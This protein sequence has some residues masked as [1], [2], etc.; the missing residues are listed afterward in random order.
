LALINED[1]PER[2][3]QFRENE[4]LM[5]ELLAKSELQIIYNREVGALLRHTDQVLGLLGVDTETLP[6]PG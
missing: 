2:L 6:E 4:S 1:G 3:A 5:G